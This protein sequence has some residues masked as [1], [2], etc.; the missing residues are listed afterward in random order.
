MP[1]HPVQF[2]TPVCKSVYFF[3]HQETDSRKKA[4]HFI[5]EHPYYGWLGILL[6]KICGVKLI[7][8]S[9]N[10][11]GI[12]WKSLNKWWWRVLWKYEKTTHRQAD[13]NFFIQDD[14][15][16]YAIKA[17]GLDERKCITVS[18]GTEIPNPPTEES[19]EA[20]SRILKKQLEVSNDQLLLLFNGSFRY[21][22]NL[23]ALQNLLYQ[24]NPLLEKKTQ[25]YVILIIGIDIPAEILNASFPNIKILGFVENL[26]LYLSGCDL[27]LNPVQ[28]GGGIK[29]KLVEALAYNLN[30]VSTQNGAIGIDPAL[31]NGKLFIAPDNNWD[32]FAAKLSSAM[33]IKRIMPPAFYDHFYWANITKRAAEFIER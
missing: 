30:A 33:E 9:H 21:T 8:H 2:K 6:K 4:T 11:E 31:C 24:I 28:S 17:F 25:P 29:T 3:Y 22:P 10:I 14:D 32:L 18:F 1:E 23:D 27:F 20:A 5:L 7:V 13:Y 12:R 15:R 16:A 19:H 26:E